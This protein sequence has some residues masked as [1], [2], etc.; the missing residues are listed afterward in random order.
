MSFTT[1]L[2]STAYL[3][4]IEYYANLLPYSKIILEQHEYFVKQSYRNRCELLSA[5]GKLALSIP[6]QERKNKSLTKD[7]RIDNSVLWQ[8]QHWKSIQ[9]AYNSSPFFEYFQDDLFPFYQNKTNYL[10]DFNFEIQEKVS[11][12]LG[13]KNTIQRSEVYQ[14]PN[15]E[16]CDARN[17]FTPKVMSTHSFPEYIQVFENKFPFVSNLSI[18][19]LLFNLGNESELYLKKLSNN[20]SSQT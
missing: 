1:L 16:T 3:A 7:I 4:P 17:K 11:E 13:L 6:L 10:I 19:D 8:L 18:L 15:K 14:N 20:L 9:S 12:L 5:N 2:I